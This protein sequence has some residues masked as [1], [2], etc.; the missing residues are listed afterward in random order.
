MKKSGIMKRVVAIA[1]AMIASSMLAISA[2]AANAGTDATISS[3]LSGD[4][5]T[6]ILNNF[7]EYTDLNKM[8]GEKGGDYNHY[9]VG[10]KYY[11]IKASDEASVKEKIEKEQKKET[12][13]DVSGKV[14]D[15]QSGLGIE[16]D[17]STATEMMKGFI[18]VIN[19]VIGALVI[20]ISIGMTIFSA[21]D[22]CYI[23]FPV[24][25]NKC[26][27]AKQSGHGLMTKKNK[28][29]GETSLRFVSD[30]AQYAVVAAD[31]TE[32]GKNPF[33]IYFGK[34]VI[35]YIVLAILLFILFTGNITVFTNMAISLVQG[36]LDLISNF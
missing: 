1:T 14:T 30:D 24:F 11:V 34:R 20:L 4:P 5:K 12:D 27:D 29:T 17:T 8:N 10:K 15:L 22:L 33:I 35:S 13:N 3:Y 16:A 25:R 31:T 2:F 32:S 21:F 36:I 6:S 23:A 18:P 9:V 19:I 28:S 26:E 7:T